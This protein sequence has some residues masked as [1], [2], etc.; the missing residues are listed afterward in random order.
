VNTTLLAKGRWESYTPVVRET[1]LDSLLASPEHLPGFLSAI[2]SGRVPASAVNSARR[3]QLSKNESI[4]ER[5][6]AL[7][8]DAGS[9]DRM[10]VYEDYKAILSLNPNAANGRAIF[11]KDCSICHRLD[12]EGV[13][14]GPDLFGIRNQSKETILL[15]IIVPEFE[16]MPAFV[17]YLVETKDGRSLSGIITS[18]T[19]QS[20]TLRGALNQEESI[21]RTN[22]ASITSTGLSLMPQELEK[23]M[24][25]QEMADLVAYLKGE[26]AGP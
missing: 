2:E 21:T 13:P 18:D 15:H 20:V 8:K 23:A 25:K 22:V 1:L 3:K 7:F 24:T 17:N 14:V 19:P 4:R 16:I 9:P 26:A 5:A 11:K 6:T 10:K 12:R